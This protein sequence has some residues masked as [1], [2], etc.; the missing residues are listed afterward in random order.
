MLC[1]GCRMHRA[2]HKRL[3]NEKKKRCVNQKKKSIPAR[4]EPSGARHLIQRSWQPLRQMTLNTPGLIGFICISLVGSKQ[5]NM[6]VAV[7]AC[8]PLDAI[9]SSTVHLPRASAPSTLFSLPL[10]PHSW[11][12]SLFCRRH[13]HHNRYPTTVPRQCQLLCPCTLGPG[14]PRSSTGRH[15]PQFGEQEG[16]R[17]TAER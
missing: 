1:Q 5:R 10:C 17:D 7:H 12:S 8:L 15:L 13:P 2:P 4:L 16:R 14:W 9:P 6:Q 11:L 3:Q